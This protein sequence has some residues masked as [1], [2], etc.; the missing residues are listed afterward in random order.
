MSLIV[1]PFLG[2]LS[3]SFLGG[4]LICIGLGFAKLIHSMPSIQISLAFIELPRFLAFPIA[5]SIGLILI[6]FS[7]MS[8]SSLKRYIKFMYPKPAL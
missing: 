2:G 5:S 6:L 8:F 7:F 3:L 4:G 1:I